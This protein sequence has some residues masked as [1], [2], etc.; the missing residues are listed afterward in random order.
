VDA[1]NGDDGELDLNTTPSNVGEGTVSPEAQFCRT[2]ATKRSTPYA[3]LVETEDTICALNMELKIA[4]EA[5]GVTR[6]DI[7]WNPFSSM[8][9]YGFSAETGSELAVGSVKQ[10]GKGRRE[11][12]KF[13]SRLYKI[14]SSK[15]VQGVTLI[16]P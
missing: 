9:L 8:Y 13:W 6:K 3:G 11:E 5:R 1:D 4:A 16:L 12:Q 14:L 7:P 15:A 2:P 10:I